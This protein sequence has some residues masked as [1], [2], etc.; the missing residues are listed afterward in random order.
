MRTG[1]TSILASCAVS[2]VCSPVP[3]QVQID[4]PGLVPTKPPSDIQMPRIVGPKTEKDA[5]KRSNAASERSPIRSFEFD[6]T[7]VP[8]E[9]GDAVPDPATVAALLVD[10]RAEAVREMPGTLL[11]AD[12]QRIHGEL[13]TKAGNALWKSTWLPDRTIAAEGVRALVLEGDVPAAAADTDVVLLRNGDRVEG[14]VTAIT[15]AGAAV[16]RMGTKDAVELPWDRIRAITFVAPPASP[17]GVRVWMADGSVIDA[18]RAAWMN[19]DFLRVTGGGAG[20]SPVTLP[21]NFVLGV[22]GMPGSAVPLGAI[23]CTAGDASDAIG[24]RYMHRRPVADAG[25]WGLDAAPLTVEGPVLLRFS[26]VP[27]GGRLV[28]RVQ[29]PERVRSVGATEL[30][31]RASGKELARQRFDASNA[32]AEWSVAIPGGPFELELL[33]ADGDPAGDMVV[34]EQALVIPA[35]MPTPAK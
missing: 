24:M 4:I 16:E 8:V 22:R 20:E 14:I 31:L 10:G 19:T 35:P 2:A 29:R 3:A 32:R 15:A 5:R 30:V 27:G 13:S 7:A 26:G 6:G 34:L 25:E 23:E 28:A 18:A 12:G 21:R 11:M 9:P 33:A 1:I 17:S